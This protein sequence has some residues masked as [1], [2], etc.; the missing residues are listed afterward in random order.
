[1]SIRK[2][3]TGQDNIV[4]AGRFNIVP[5]THTEVDQQA[6]DGYARYELGTNLYMGLYIDLVEMRA[7]NIPIHE[8]KYAL[9]RLGLNTQDIKSGAPIKPVKFLYLH[10]F[11]G[12]ALK[13]YVR[14]KAKSPS[15]LFLVISQ[16]QDHFSTFR[17]LHKGPP[18]L[19][20]RFENGQQVEQ[21]VRIWAIKPEGNPFLI[22]QSLDSNGAKNLIIKNGKGE[23]IF[24]PKI[25]LVSPPPPAA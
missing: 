15:S 16:D 11:Y 9:E 13:A 14:E 6:I 25:T 5:P 22:G 20:N 1:M 7:R 3:E 21:P 4:G 24:P 18:P 12:Q 10:T 17:D 23:Q 8:Q 2:V 19:H